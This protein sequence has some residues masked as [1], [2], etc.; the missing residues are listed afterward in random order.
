MTTTAVRPTRARRAVLISAAAVPVLILGQFAMLAIVPVAIAVIAGARM[1]GVRLFTWVLG[2]LY[3]TPLIIW[4]LR[5]NPARS[6]SRDIDPIFAALIIA[7]AIAVLIAIVR[8]NRK[9]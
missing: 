6:L 4:A 7:G 2:A 9:A 3:A 1:K 5:E 8:S